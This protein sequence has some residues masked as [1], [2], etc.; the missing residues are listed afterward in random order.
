MTKAPKRDLGQGVSRGCKPATF[1]SRCRMG[2]GATLIIS[3]VST[4]AVPAVYSFHPSTMS[5]IK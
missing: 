2:D 3:K 1:D 5:T 4:Q